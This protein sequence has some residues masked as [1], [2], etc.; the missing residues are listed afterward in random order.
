M[1]SPKEIS[2][3]GHPI[4]STPPTNTTNHQFLVTH[5]IW[6]SK[7]ERKQERW[8]KFKKDSLFLLVCLIRRDKMREKKEVDFDKY[9]YIL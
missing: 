5:Y 2:D 1:L 4:Q 9:I 6:S 3:H 8:N 7:I